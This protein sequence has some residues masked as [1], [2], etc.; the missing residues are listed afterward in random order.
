[1]LAAPVLTCHH[2]TSGQM[3]NAHGGVRSVDVL[4][5]GARS[6]VNV[7]FQVA[8][9]DLDIHFCRLRQHR[10]SRRAGVNAPA[11]LGHRHA[12]HAV[13][14]AF[15]F[16][17]GKHACALDR[18]DHFLK[19]THVGGA[20]RNRL[21]LPPLPSGIAFIHAVQVAREQSG[22]IAACARTN[23]QHRGS[24]IRRIAGQ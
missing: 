5:A 15:I 22:F 4:P 12:L 20:D 18:D 6:T 8:R 17:L 9:L 24:V 19:S 21:N 3:G 11:A 1:M 23:F 10:D 16:Q 2:N 7:D 13:D 14:A